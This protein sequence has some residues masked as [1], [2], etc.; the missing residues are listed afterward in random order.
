MNNKDL[1]T[2]KEIIT[3]DKNY[4]YVKT[5]FKNIDLIGE[6]I[7]KGI[8][9]GFDIYSYI[10][11]LYELACLVKILVDNNLQKFL[12]ISSGIKFKTHLKK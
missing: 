12:L 1:I 3:Q 6:I 5:V 10:D 9:V 2:S 7:K 8:I 4:P 11:E